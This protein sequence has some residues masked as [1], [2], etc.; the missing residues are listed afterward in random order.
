MAGLSL[1]LAGAMA[2]DL[3]RDWV[4]PATGHRIIRLTDQPGSLSMYFNFNAITPEGDKMVITTPDGIAAVDLKTHALKT[5][6]T[7]KVHLLFVGRKSRQVYYEV[8]DSNSAAA[9]D[10]FTANIDSGKTHKLVHIEHGTIQTINAD[11]T[12]IAGVDEQN[13]TVAIGHDGMIQP[14]DKRLP[15][16]SPAPVLGP[17]GKPL[18]F[19]LGKESRMNQRLEAKIPM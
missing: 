5:I 15:V 2:A 4:D 9:K 16:D 7:G 19:A 6:V 8:G 12:K 3:P 13:H 17:D 14:P 11:E 10:I 18:T 1:S